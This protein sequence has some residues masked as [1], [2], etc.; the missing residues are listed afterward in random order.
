M[1]SECPPL[2]GILKAADSGLGRPHAFRE[3]LLSQTGL[4]AQRV[5]LPRNPGVDD[6][7]GRGPAPPCFC[8]HAMGKTPGAD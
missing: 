8:R 5:N 7:L 2:I 3:F 4:G 6:F 1:E